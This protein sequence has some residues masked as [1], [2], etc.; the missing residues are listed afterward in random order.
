LFQ[1]EH[2]ATDDVVALEEVSVVCLYVEAIVLSRIFLF[3]KKTVV[4]TG[5]TGLATV[6]AIRLESVF[7][8]EECFDED[9]G[10]SLVVHH[11]D[12]LGVPD[13]ETHFKFFIRLLSYVIYWLHVLGGHLGWVDFNPALDNALRH[14]R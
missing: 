11:F 2:A 3:K 10:G 7:R 12:F 13:H 4:E 6:M 8:V 1:I 5:L 14:S 9:I